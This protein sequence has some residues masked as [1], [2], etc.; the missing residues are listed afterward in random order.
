VPTLVKSNEKNVASMLGDVFV[1]LPRAVI[2]GDASV[3]FRSLEDD[4][5]TEL[6][7]LVKL[8]KLVFR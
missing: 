3:A 2:Y 1:F 4:E 8:V 5:G 6:P 7:N